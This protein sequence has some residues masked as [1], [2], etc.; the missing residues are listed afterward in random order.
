MLLHHNRTGGNPLQFTGIRRPDGQQ[1]GTLLVQ[2]FVSRETVA[3]EFRCTC[4][5]AG[6]LGAKTHRRRE[7]S[8]EL[9]SH[10]TEG[11]RLVR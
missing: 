2:V 10:R 9:F 7:S 3:G 11:E 4:E 1:G 5:E 6:G 8:L